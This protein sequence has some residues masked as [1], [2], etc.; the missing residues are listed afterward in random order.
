MNKELEPKHT[1][2][3]IEAILNSE[4]YKQQYSATASKIFI[5]PNL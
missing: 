1:P 3:L 5:H 4:Y 2:N